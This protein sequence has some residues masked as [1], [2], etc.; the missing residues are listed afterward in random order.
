MPSGVNHRLRPF[1]HL[2][3]S[4]VSQSGLLNLVWDRGYNLPHGQNKD[5]IPEQ[6]QET[7]KRDGTAD[8][9]QFCT[10]MLKKLQGTTFRG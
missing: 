9:A 10:G 2:P 3:S 6:V 7:K 5:V 1:S 4:T 8:T